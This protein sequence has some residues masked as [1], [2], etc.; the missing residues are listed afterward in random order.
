VGGYGE[1]GAERREGG[2]GGRRVLTE[3]MK[4]R[5]DSLDTLLGLLPGV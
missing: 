3:E 1:A 5:A 2:R 4:K